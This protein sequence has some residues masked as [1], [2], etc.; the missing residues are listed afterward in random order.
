MV[1]D[2]TGGK[3]YEDKQWNSA[4]GSVGGDGGGGSSG[5]AVDE[6]SLQN[7]YIY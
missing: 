3:G 5:A 4:E 2:I 7:K 1:Q 6:V